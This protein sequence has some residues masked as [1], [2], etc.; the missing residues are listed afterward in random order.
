MAVYVAQHRQ[1]G[2][3][4][5]S[6]NSIM[7]KTPMTA[8][9]ICLIVLI[10]PEI[11]RAGRYAR[12]GGSSTRTNK[13]G[14]PPGPTRHHRRTNLGM[15]NDSRLAAQPPA[16]LSTDDSREPC[17]SAAIGKEGTRWTPPS[18]LNVQAGSRSPAGIDRTARIRV[19]PRAGVF[20]MLDVGALVAAGGR[21]HVKSGRLCTP[22][23][24]SVC[25]RPRRQPV[26]RTA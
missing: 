21:R 16:G 20:L 10:V 18:Q 5:N 25:V 15:V 13:R 22:A 19:E 26:S 14:P 8:E 24:L 12:P 1:F 6:L 17:S 4:N 2:W 11:Y 9:H 23:G 3:F 7:P